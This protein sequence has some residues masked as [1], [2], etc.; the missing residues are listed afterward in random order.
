MT[1]PDANL[2]EQIVVAVERRLADDMSG[3]VGEAGTS[4]QPV[5]AGGGDEVECV[6]RI[7]TGE[8]LSERITSETRQL[9]IR[10]SSILTP[11]ARELIA[12]HELLVTVDLEV[13]QLGCGSDGQSEP[14]WLLLLVGSDVAELRGLVSERSEGIE[15]AVS[16]VCERLSSV[17]GS[18]VV[19]LSREPHRLAC[20]A[21]RRSQ[22]RA[23]VVRDAEEAAGLLVRLGANLVVACPLATGA[24]QSRQ[25]VETCL[26]AESP[27]V[28]ED[29]PS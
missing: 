7:V 29:W 11:T 18:G 10:K 24:W 5:V 13:G 27:R 19:V 17:E 12:R 4:V 14:G 20:L 2:I 3:G 16:C 23:V 9:R 28:P 6:E 25:I 26:A 22:V 8:M 21:N 15:L 1:I